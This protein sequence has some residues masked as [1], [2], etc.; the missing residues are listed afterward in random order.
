[1]QKPVTHSGVAFY[2]FYFIVDLQRYT[3]KSLKSGR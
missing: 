2:I 3:T 1:M